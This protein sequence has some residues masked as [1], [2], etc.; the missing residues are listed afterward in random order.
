MDIKIGKNCLFILVIM[1]NTG[2]V[3]TLWGAIHL[4]SCN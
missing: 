1:R 2:E 3:E 4:G